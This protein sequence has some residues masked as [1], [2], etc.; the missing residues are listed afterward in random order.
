METIVLS[1][2]KN[3]LNKCCVGKVPYYQLVWNIFIKRFMLQLSVSHILWGNKISNGKN[4]AN[5]S[6]M[7]LLT[8]QNVYNTD[9]D[10]D[11]LFKK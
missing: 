4:L 7:K 9:T 11:A 8:N 2:E 5:K 3:K 10:Q 6:F 1:K